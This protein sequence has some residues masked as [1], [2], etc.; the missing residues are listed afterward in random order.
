MLN[1][2]EAIPT[3]IIRRTDRDIDCICNLVLEP[4]R[5]RIS[6]SEMFQS[7]EFEVRQ[8]W[9][10]MCKQYCEHEATLAD[11]FKSHVDDPGYLLI[12]IYV[13]VL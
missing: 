7:T 6:V 8:S 3:K 4:L 1:I 2:D 13:L 12:R 10:R 11:R 9:T 5:V